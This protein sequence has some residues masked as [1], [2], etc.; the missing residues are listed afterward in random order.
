MGA[1]NKKGMKP[2]RT[3]GHENPDAG[4]GT[5][6]DATEAVVPV[7][8][9]QCASGV[10]RA[11]ADDRCRL[12]ALRE[13]PLPASR[14]SPHTSELEIHLHD[15][16]LPPSTKNSG[17]C[18][19]GSR[20]LHRTVSVDA[21]SP[22]RTLAP[23][24]HRAQSRSRPG[25]TDRSEWQE[26]ECAKNSRRLH[27]RGEWAS[28]KRGHPQESASKQRLL[29][30]NFSANRLRSRACSPSDNERRGACGFALAKITSLKGE[31]R[32]TSCIGLSAAPVTAAVAFL[33]V[34]K[35]RANSPTAL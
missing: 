15:Q 31:L 20:C 7:R 34:R 33:L 26:L 23:H 18:N 17:R 30:L 29:C 11:E 35:G 14:H 4:R 21:P 25:S 19:D 28:V 16:W 2:A 6:S 12:A 5:E 8:A 3:L 27:V 1:L 13:H 22:R 32:P 24:A 9:R 10:K